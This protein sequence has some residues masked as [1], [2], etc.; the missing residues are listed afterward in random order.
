MAD[1]KTKPQ[2]P[3]KPGITRRDLLKWSAATG[4]A[5]ALG[6]LARPARASTC[7]GLSAIEGFPVSPLILQPF[8]EPLP[9]PT[10][11]A[12]EAPGY[13]ETWSNCPGP[14]EG[15]PGLRRRNPPALPRHERHRL[16][17]DAGSA[18][19]TG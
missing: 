16:R 4:A 12:P 7:S 17:G 13:P 9:V 2:A 10:A 15:R 11:Y 5:A 6:T 8:T 3:R 14:E 18:S 1:T 19:S